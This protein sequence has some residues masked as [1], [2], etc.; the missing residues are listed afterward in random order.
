MSRIV[1]SAYYIAPEVVK[2]AYSN[3]C[4]LWS[5]GVLTFMVCFHL[6]LSLF[7]T[8]M[9]QTNIQTQ[10][11]TGSPPFRGDG[12][13]DVVGKIESSNGVR[14]EPFR[15]SKSCKEF[16]RGLLQIDPE[17]RWSAE[18]ALSHHWIKSATRVLEMNGSSGEK[19]KID[20][21]V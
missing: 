16:V 4:D 5:I 6:S 13:M 9:T 1:G 11:V 14:F 17:A 7:H 19:E 8:L 10:L 21:N 15:V 18:Q 3:A 2:G 12:I 20:L